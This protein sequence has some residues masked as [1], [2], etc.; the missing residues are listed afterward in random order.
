[1]PSPRPCYACAPML[2]H[3]P[4]LLPLPH[5]SRPHALPHILL[6]PACALRPTRLTPRCPPIRHHSLQLP[7]SIYHFVCYLPRLLSPHPLVLRHRQVSRYHTCCVACG[8][9]QPHV[10]GTAH[11]APRGSGLGGPRATARRRP[12][13]ARCTRTR[14]CASLWYVVVVRA[15]A[16]RYSVPPSHMVSAGRD[17]LNPESTPSY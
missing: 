5:H 12:A 13:T 16:D 17:H 7:D 2:L 15:I 8:R 14:V 1:M 6:R 10:S 3:Y 11:G 4:G 9:V